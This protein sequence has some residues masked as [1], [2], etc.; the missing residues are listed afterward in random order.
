MISLYFHIPFCYK[1]CNYCSFYIFPTSK[2]KNIEEYKDKYLEA[3]KADILYQL[4][5]FKPSKNVYTIYF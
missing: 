2:I 3:L 5:K 1:K 4:E